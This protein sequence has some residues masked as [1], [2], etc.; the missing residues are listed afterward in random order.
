[1]GLDERIGKNEA[2][3]REV[4]ERIEAGQLPADTDQRAAFC[5]ECAQLGCNALVEMTIAEYE[6]VRAHPRRFL[7]A[8]GHQ[9][10]DAERVVE[11]T[12][13]YIVVEKIG[14]AGKVAQSSDP[15]S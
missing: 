10:D 1:V 8:H 2:I 14:D 4:N 9:I 12:G 7:V 6:H 5:C 15:R 3:F 13:G 11:S